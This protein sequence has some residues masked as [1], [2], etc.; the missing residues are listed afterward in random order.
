MNGSASNPILTWF[1]LSHQL[2]KKGLGRSPIPLVFRFKKDICGGS[3]IQAQCEFVCGVDYA[4]FVVF[5][6]V[7]KH[8]T[9]YLSYLISDA[10]SK[11]HVR[12]T[13]KRFNF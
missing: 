7:K 3:R 2:K 9:K 6:L 11:I 5:H 13:S 4:Y 10:T 1:S 8:I 12:Y